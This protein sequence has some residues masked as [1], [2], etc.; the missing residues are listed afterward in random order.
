MSNPFQ[1]EIT[2]KQHTPII[3]FQHDQ[4]GATLRASEVKPKLDKFII[5]TF[6]LLERTIINNT[7]TITP[8]SQFKSFFVNDGKLHTAL[9]YKIK[10][11]VN[12]VDT[13]TAIT[14]KPFEPKTKAGQQIYEQKYSYPMVLTNM[15]GKSNQSELKD[16]TIYENLS[17]VFNSFN[18]E[19]LK[20]IKQVIGGFFLLHNF[21]N[22]Q[23]KGFGSFTVI[24]IDNIEEDT[25]QFPAGT[26]FLLINEK[27][28][29]KQMFETIDYYWKRLKSGI[30]YSKYKVGGEAG[31]PIWACDPSRYE[32]AFLFDYIN[33]Y[34]P[35][36]QR[37][38]WEKRWLKESFLDLDTRSNAIPPKYARALLGLQDKFEFINPDFCNPDDTESAQMNENFR[39]LNIKVKH[40]N[41]EIDRIKAPILFKPVFHSNRIFIYIIIDAKHINDQIYEA[42]INKEFEFTE[43][44]TNN[45]S[46]PNETLNFYDLLD[47]YH[48]H[49]GRNFQSK[50]FQW[51]TIANVQTM[52]TQ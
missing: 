16:F 9:D 45:L 33:N 47:K 15:G 5:S 37:Y 43:E 52:K 7:E 31:N 49:L 11:S 28:E 13:N 40:E 4:A 34:L 14:L 36:E 3:H 44:A 19:L 18:T 12:S 20:K 8:K 24:Q 39:K 27:I 46:L 21:G 10:I 30:N 23:S 29:L 42:G 22:R 26:H 25:I 50:N 41:E 32:K 17:I 35:Q 6:Q 51:K 48:I 1:L 38:T 2:L